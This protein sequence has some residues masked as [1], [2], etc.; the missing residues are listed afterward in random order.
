MSVILS[1]NRTWAANAGEIILREE[2]V[3]ATIEAIIGVRQARF[4]RNERGYHGRFYCSLLGA[5]EHR[6]LL[7]GDRIVEMEYQKSDRHGLTQRPDIVFHIPAEISGS[8]VNENNYAV[9]ALKQAASVAEAKDDFLKLDDMFRILRYPLGIFINI[10]SNRHHLNSY[11]GPY[12]DR[13]MAFAVLSR[14]NEVRITF[15][16]Y[17]PYGNIEESVVS[18]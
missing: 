14:E 8:A 3:A 7:T 11:E 10:R 18:A 15:A 16:Q 2:I 6:N 1:R 17:L 13:L 9:W 12:R 5:L 4:F